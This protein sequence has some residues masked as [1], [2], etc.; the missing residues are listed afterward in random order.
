MLGEMRAG[1][2]P[3]WGMSATL[4]LAPALPATAATFCVNSEATAQA[5]L[6]TA[7]TNDEA[8]TIRFRSGV[9]ELVNGLDFTTASSAAD[10]LALTLAGGYNAGCAQRTG[11]TFLDGNGDVRPLEMRLFGP[12]SVVIDRLTFIDGFAT[13]GGGNLF[14][15]MFDQDGGASVRI[16]N[17]G[18]LVGSSASGGAG[19]DITGWGTLR[20]RNNLV[21]GNAG[22]SFPAGRINLTGDIFLVG[23]TITANAT[24]DGQGWALYTNATTAASS[25]WLSNNILWGNDSFGDVYLFGAGTVTLVN[26]NIGVRTNPTLGGASGGNL[27]VDPQFAACGVVC[28]SR[29]LARSSPLV[30]AGV[31]NPQGG[32]PTTDFDGNARLVGPNV[33]IGAYEL[34]R[35]FDDGFE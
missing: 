11:T 7:T 22:P 3:A 34:D 28:I 16:D 4:A 26:N 32:R 14:I 21:V 2:W 19:F 29:Q 23:N 27:S 6:A 24:T 9:I 1:R 10:D 30:D 25:Q 17:S 31:N 18:F 15:G 20:F 5:A 33:D 13:D 8:D 35:L 12:Q